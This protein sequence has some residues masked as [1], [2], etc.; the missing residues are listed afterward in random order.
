MGLEILLLGII[1]GLVSIA[2]IFNTFFSIKEKKIRRDTPFVK[3]PGLIIRSIFDFGL[4]R[5][6]VIT[7]T[8]HPKFYYMA[9]IGDIVMAIFTGVLSIFFILL[10]FDIINITFLLNQIQESFWKRS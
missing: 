2:F 10:F 3:E 1:F 8:N 4:K 9:I 7:P 5:H 6:E